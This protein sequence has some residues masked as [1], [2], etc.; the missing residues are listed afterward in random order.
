M[1]F[2]FSTT[3][4][5]WFNRTK[6]D[7]AES[8]FETAKNDPTWSFGF[9]HILSNFEDDWEGKRGKVKKELLQ[10]FLE[11]DQLLFVCG[12]LGFN[13]HVMSILNEIGIKSDRVVVFQ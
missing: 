1:S 2:T 5:L 8:L 7:I 11:D 12:P 4:L 13:E 10:N 6:K 3:K 9:E